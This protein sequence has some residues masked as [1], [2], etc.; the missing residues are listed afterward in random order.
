MVV[1]G[2]R[3]TRPVHGQPGRRCVSI[4]AQTTVCFSLCFPCTHVS[5]FRQ[6]YFPMLRG[7]LKCQLLRYTSYSTILLFRFSCI[8]VMV[9]CARF[10]LCRQRPLCVC[11][12]L[13]RMDSLS[14]ISTSL[15]NNLGGCLMQCG[16]MIRLRAQGTRGIASTML[17][18]VML[19]RWSP[20]CRTTHITVR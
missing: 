17:S 12:L 15:D 2:S 13:Q 18:T 4:T 16:N 8:L 9:L 19:R 10:H 1:V 14:Q 11:E 5:F 3:S 20:Q 6:V 7:R